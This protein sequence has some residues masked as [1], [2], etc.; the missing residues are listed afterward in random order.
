MN[1]TPT[2]VASYGPSTLSGALL[3]ELYTFDGVGAM[4]SRDRYEETRVAKPGDWIEIKSILE[5]LAKDG[6]TVAM[7][8]DALVDEVSAGAFHVME[9]DGKIIGCA[10]L[11][12]YVVERSAD[13]GD[14]DGAGEA[15][16]AGE[17]ETSTGTGAQVI[18]EVASFA[19][20]PGYRNEGRGDKLLEY[21]ERV[22]RDAGVEKMFLLTT[23]TADWFTQRGFLHA[24]VAKDSPLLPPGKVTQ[25]GRNSQLYIR[26]LVR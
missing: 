2:F 3:L 15:G 21:L 4:I 10:A 14:G 1:S 13:D 19:V 7:S 23:R 20:R 5:P 22:A 18:A 17:D 8:D 26:T 11:R 12:R 24:G 6:T 16:E 9:R 25:E